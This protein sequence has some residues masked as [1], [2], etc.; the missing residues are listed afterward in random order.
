MVPV[1]SAGKLAMLPG[2]NHFLGGL[3]Y[4]LVGLT[5]P[6]FQII[7]RFPSLTDEGCCQERPGLDLVEIDIDILYKFHLACCL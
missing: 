1:P 7:E 3:R 4:H 2:G 5:C 6:A